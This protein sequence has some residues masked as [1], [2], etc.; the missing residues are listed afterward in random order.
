VVRN[1][2]VPLDVGDQAGMNRIRVFF[3]L[4]IA[5]LMVGC[6][7]K[8]SSLLSE[9]W[10][11]NYSLAAYGAEASHPEINDGNMRTWGIT[12]SPDRVYSITFP[13]EKKLSRIAVYSGNVID[14]ELF[15]WDREAGKWKLVDDASRAR[16]RKIVNYERLKFEMLQFDH[17]LNLKTD[18]I[19]LQVKRAES[20]GITTTRTPGK[21]DR[22]IGS[23]IETIG[24]GRS[25]I[26]I[27]LYDVFVE[28]P[29]SIRE[30]EAYG[31]MEKPE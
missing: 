11:E 28:G 12:R 2:T 30:I 19:K 18:K 17:R 1:L 22:I 9:S 24:T 6:S 16:V 23:R 7:P 27:T 25:S 21:N 15:C 13:E 14:Y 10:S 26:H 4:Y 29:A 31:H 3:L 5:L 20:D 8:F